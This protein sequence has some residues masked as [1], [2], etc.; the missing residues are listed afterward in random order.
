MLNETSGKILFQEK[1]SLEQSGN[2]T[3]LN[4]FKGFTV[5]N[6]EYILW[7]DFKSAKD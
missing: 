5:K 7:D 4:I 2:Q 3:Q 6:K 1:I